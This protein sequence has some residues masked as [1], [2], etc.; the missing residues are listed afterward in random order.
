MHAEIAIVVSNRPNALAIDRAKRQGIAVAIFDRS[1]YSSRHDRDMAMLKCLRQHNLD[2]VVMA[3]YDQ[4]VADAL[5][6]EFEGK[7]INI[8]PSLLP[9]FAGGLHAQRDAF[10]YGVKISGCTVHFVTL[11]PADGGPI[12]L[13]KAVPVLDDDTAGK[14][15]G[16]ILNEEHIALPE[17]IGLFVE[18][19]IELEGRRVRVRRVT[20]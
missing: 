17:A 6:L 18:R 11:G 10:E 3:G 14:L 8:H 19:R 12:I 2:L 16:R 1:E 15:A 7:I 9:A 20:G 5:L 4:L 13:Q